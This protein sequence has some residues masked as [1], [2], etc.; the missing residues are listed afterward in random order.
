MEDLSII[1]LVKIILIILFF[2]LDAFLKFQYFSRFCLDFAQIFK[3][4]VTF[5]TPVN[6]YKKF[7]YQIPVTS[8]CPLN[9]FLRLCFPDK[10]SK[11]AKARESNKMNVNTRDIVVVYIGFRFGFFLDFTSEGRVDYRYSKSAHFW[12]I[13]T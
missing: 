9:N 11:S 2:F 8:Y 4:F 3:A 6:Q 1:V 13:Y 5:Q 10:G 7:R 12:G